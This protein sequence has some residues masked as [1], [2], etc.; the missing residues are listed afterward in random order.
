MAPLEEYCVGVSHQSAKRNC[1]W[2]TCPRSLG[3]G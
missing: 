3:Y 1:K 2:R